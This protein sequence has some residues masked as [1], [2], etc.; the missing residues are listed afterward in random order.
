MNRYVVVYNEC[1]KNSIQLVTKEFKGN[2]LYIDPIN[3]HALIDNISICDN[4]NHINHIKFLVN[5]YY[6]TILVNPNGMV[7]TSDE[8][9][10]T[11]RFMKG[12]E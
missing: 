8:D 12:G 1:Y 6:Q 3:K 10:P 7:V 4:Y 2:Y 5:G 9:L 11:N